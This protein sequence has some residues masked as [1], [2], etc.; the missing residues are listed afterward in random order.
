MLE[1]GWEGG[2]DCRLRSEEIERLIVEVIYGKRFIKLICRFWLCIKGIFVSVD[3]LFR[4]VFIVKEVKM[5]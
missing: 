1:S 5:F 4:G 2:G 3:M